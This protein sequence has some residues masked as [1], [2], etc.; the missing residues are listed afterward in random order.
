MSRFLHR[1]RVLAACLVVAAFAL[2]AQAAPKQARGGQ[3]RMNE[4]Q[5][6]GTH[7]SYKR[8]APPQ[9]VAAHDAIVGQVGNYDTFSAYSHLSLTSQL[10]RQNV[11]S[12]ELDLWA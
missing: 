7:N 10:A 8:E 4:I 12:F 3:V 5:V 11:R 9:E 6:I 2:P 1:W